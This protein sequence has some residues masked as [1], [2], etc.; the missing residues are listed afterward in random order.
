M[1]LGIAIDFG[2]NFPF[3][4][5]SDSFDRAASATIALPIILPDETQRRAAL[6]GRPPQRRA[7]LTLHNQATS[8]APAARQQT[9]VQPMCGTTI[10]AVNKLTQQE[11]K[12]RERKKKGKNAQQT[13]NLVKQNR[14]ASTAGECKTF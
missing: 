11:N 2:V 9:N 8:S 4:P 3:K 12:K 13:G 5:L 10:A 1:S 6:S 14:A 7:S